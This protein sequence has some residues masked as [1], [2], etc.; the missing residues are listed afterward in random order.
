MGSLTADIAQNCNSNS[1]GFNG[2]CLSNGEEESRKDNGE[3]FG[4]YF[5][6]VEIWPNLSFD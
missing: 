1:I 6:V 5:D 3:V 2:R 4:E